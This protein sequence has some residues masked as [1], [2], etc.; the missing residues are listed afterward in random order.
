M[1]SIAELEAALGELEELATR[2]R[3]HPT[4]HHARAL[5]L[6]LGSLLIEGGVEPEETTARVAQAT[7]SYEDRWR[8]AMTEEMQLASAEYVTSVDESYLD[9]PSYDFAYTSEARRRLEARLRACDALD[10]P[11]PEGLLDR[12][13]RADEIYAPYEERWQGRE[14]D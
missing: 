3:P 9:M 6:P 10:H 1:D 2:K 7:R 12:V 8:A 4:R 5:L 13:R 11:L 14:T